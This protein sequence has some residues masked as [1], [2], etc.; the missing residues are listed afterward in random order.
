LDW[1][2]SPCKGLTDCSDV[3]TRLDDR[4][5]IVLS[6]EAVIS[7]GLVLCE[8]RAVLLIIATNEHHLLVSVRFALVPLGGLK[9]HEEPE[10]DRVKRVTKSL[11]ATGV[12]K[13][14][15]AVD[16][17]TGVVLDG[18]HRL[19]ALQTLGCARVPASLID[20]SSKDIVVFAKDRKSLFP[21][22]LV[23]K[24]ALEGPKLPPKSTHHMVREKD[25][26]VHI[27]KLEKDVSVPLATLMQE[28]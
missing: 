21:K 7:L 11:Q 18:V 26:L 28:A 6:V 20:Y 10:A 15:I 3:L 19:S 23:I 8:V 16:S 13:K 5:A 22:E 9:T 27:S 14:A 2:P 4:P 24:A 1:G 25:A 17:K 12:M